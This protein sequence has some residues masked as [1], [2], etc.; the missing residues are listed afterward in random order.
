LRKGDDMKAQKNLGRVGGRYVDPS[1]PVWLQN[2][3]LF[4]LGVVAGYCWA[5]NAGA[6]YRAERTIV[7]EGAMV[8]D[9]YIIKYNGAGEFT[10]VPK[11]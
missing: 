9:G 1:M 5:W 3:I 11:E 8:Q 10:A 2:V 6:T 4:C 7:W